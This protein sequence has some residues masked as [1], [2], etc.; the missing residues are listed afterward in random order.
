VA[1]YVATGLRST[2]WTPAVATDKALEI[3]WVRVNDTV[4]VA[5]LYNPPR[6]VYRPEVLLDHL[7]ACV[8]E[9]THDHPQVE[10]VIAGDLNQMSD[11]DLIERTGLTQVVRQA[12]RG[13]NVLDRVLVSSPDLYSKVRVVKSAVRSD[14][15]AIVALADRSHPLP[16]TRVQRP[17]RRHMPVQHARFLQNAATIDLSNPF[18]TVS[19]DP[20]MNTQAEFDNFYSVASKL[21]AEYYPEQTVTLSSRDPTY[22][23]PNIKSML[24]RKNK[25]VRGGR[26]EKAGALSARIG[27]AIQR[28]CKQQ[29]RR[30]YGKT[31]A[32]VR[33]L[34]GRESRL[35]QLESMES[36]QRC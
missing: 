30:Y 9:I 32:A 20:A 3:E 24:R 4:F 33:R 5:A 13:N 23:T 31:W 36:R 26:V 29:L 12:T 28:R 21:M 19:A 17:Y 25:L 10:I 18:L 6:P 16:K 7:E 35:H 14:H 1:L 34:T 15:K 8:T 22:M 27:Q 2:R 11:C